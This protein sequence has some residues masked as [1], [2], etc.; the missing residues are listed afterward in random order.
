MI[1]PF[2]YLY[3]N[4][5]RKLAQTAIVSCERHAI[6]TLRAFI[7][8][9]ADWD[10]ALNYIQRNGWQMTALLQAKSWYYSKPFLRDLLVEFIIRLVC[11]LLAGYLAN[12]LNEWDSLLQENN[13]FHFDSSSW[14]KWSH[15]MLIIKA[16]LSWQVQLANSNY[17]FQT[18]C[19]NRV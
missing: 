4:F 12:W 1:S 13:C 7:E 6:L 19:E 18:W 3:Q 9:L 14:S 15:G 10:L 2:Y 5:G 16:L 8:L 17:L 11:I